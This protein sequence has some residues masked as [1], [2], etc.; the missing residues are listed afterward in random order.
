[1]NKQWPFFVLVRIDTIFSVIVSKVP[2]SKKT[3]TEKG[4]L[5][6]AVLF[7]LTFLLEQ[8]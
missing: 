2:R 3:R 8:D 7:I 6:K 5:L 1:M 4:F